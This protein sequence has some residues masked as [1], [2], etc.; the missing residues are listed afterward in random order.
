MNS[1]L[2]TDRR[3]LFDLSTAEGQ[4]HKDDPQSR[5]YNSTG[6]ISA[7]LCRDELCFRR[8]EDEHASDCHSSFAVQVFSSVRSPKKGVTLL[9]PCGGGH[10]LVSVQAAYKKF[11]YKSV[12]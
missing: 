7:V 12:R 10:A 2:T 3:T 11:Y 1:E 4:Q 8:R 9:L 5:C 6:G